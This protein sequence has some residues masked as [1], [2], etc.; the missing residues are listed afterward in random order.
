MK[1]TTVSDV[2]QH[3]VNYVKDNPGT[4]FAELEQLFD[5][6]NFEWHGNQLIASS[7]H[8]NLCYWSDWNQQATELINRILVRDH[9]KMHV[10]DLLTYYTD[11]KTL[12]LPIA[13]I[14]RSYRQLH[15]LPVT[16]SI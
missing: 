6:C 3:I 11:G 12:T 4:S 2:E 13:R 5:D 7:H 8:Q 9:I 14:Q 16:L 10:S 1:T 15:W